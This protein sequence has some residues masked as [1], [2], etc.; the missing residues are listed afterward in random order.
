MN[1]EYMRMSF[2]EDLKNFFFS[3]WPI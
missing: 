2:K 3:H 1:P